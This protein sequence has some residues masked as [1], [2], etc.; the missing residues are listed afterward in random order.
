MPK[1]SGRTKNL[2][3]GAEEETGWTHV[4]P[5]DKEA[6]KSLQAFL[7][8]EGGGEKL[9][10]PEGVDIDDLEDIYEIN[11]ELIGKDA[12]TL[13][14]SNVQNL[15]RLYN[16][17][18]F[19][20]EHPD[21]KRRIDTEIES[22]RMLYKMKH[23]NEEVHDHL[24]N[25]IAKHPGNASLYMALDR[26]QGKMLSIDKQIR[27]QIAGFNKIITGYQME[28][29]FA[30]DNDLNGGDSST[31]ELDDGSVMSRGGK[32]FVEQMKSRREKEAGNTGI[33][34]D[35]LDPDNLPAGWKVDEET[36]EVYDEDTGEVVGHANL[37]SH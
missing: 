28:L 7:F 10:M 1:G 16:N 13:A 21:F 22:L 17:K 4:D 15:L 11:I 5:K 25:S 37:D 23:I 26:M 14:A 18:Q 6:M 31:A 34:P 24:V 12:N 33:D 30:Q 9:G 3:Y 35:K 27:D 8:N 20:D 19:T 29:N 32:A 36:G 2:R